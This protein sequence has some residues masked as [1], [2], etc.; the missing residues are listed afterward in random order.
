MTEPF[1]TTY[2]LFVD[3]L[4]FAALVEAE[5]DEL[6]ELDPVFTG[7]ELYPS[8]EKS[9]LGFRFI[10]FHRCLNDARV[11]LQKLGT[12]TAIV[13]SDSAFLRID[14]LEQA[15]DVA[16]SLMFDLVSNE[17]PARIGIARGS[18]RMLRF[19]TDSSA[20]ASF[21]VSQF[22]GTGVVRAYKTE[23]C[24][25]PGL[26]ILLHPDLEPLLDKDAMRIIPAKPGEKM[27]LGV[28][29]EVNYLDPKT[30][31]HL[32]KDYE[33]CL[34]F[35]ALRWMVNTA[36]E[37]FHYHY[38]ETFHALNVMRAQLGRAP[39]SW[40]KFLDRDEYDYSHGIRTRPDAKES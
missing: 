11:R 31:S 1:A 33:D 32:G 2:I 30:D 12:G 27:H 10:N 18:Y 26:R 4:G 21:H 14:T 19:L 38:I 8:S 36:D 24:G 40:D 5:G 37:A 9:L 6:N 16:R 20:Q 34:Q 7:V 28:R 15:I 3:M 35:D 17:V 23:R 29:S 22:L 25:I 39:Y 13:F